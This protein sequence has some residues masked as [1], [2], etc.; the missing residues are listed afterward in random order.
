MLYHGLHEKNNRYLGV[1]NGFLPRCTIYTNTL[2]G[3]AVRIEGVA[4]V[5]H[6]DIHAERYRVPAI[7]VAI[8]LS[9]LLP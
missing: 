5:L 8:F 6:T 7:F 2:Q 9:F 1:I 3:R 4:I